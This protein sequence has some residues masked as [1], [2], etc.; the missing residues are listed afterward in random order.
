MHLLLERGNPESSST[1]A[2][3]VSRSLGKVKTLPDFHDGTVRRP[4][5]MP[6]FRVLGL[7]LGP[8]HKKS[9]LKTSL[10]MA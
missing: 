6:W 9:I 2:S 10:V 7:G 4:Y 8:Q 1:T 5:T 3:Q